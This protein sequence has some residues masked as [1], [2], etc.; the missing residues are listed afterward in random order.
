MLLISSFLYNLFKHILS[1]IF[2]TLLIDLIDTILFV[3]SYI[4]AYFQHKN[5]YLILFDELPEV[6]SWN[7]A[8][9]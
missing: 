5:I 9:G 2:F 7:V 8:Y 1:T 3:L 4:T 6:L